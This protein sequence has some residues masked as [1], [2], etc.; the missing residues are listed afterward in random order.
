MQID[1]YYRFEKNNDRKSK[2]RYELTFNQGYYEPLHQ[3]N[4][5][6]ECWIYFGYNPRIKT[7]NDRKSDVA[8]STRVSKHITSVFI[9]E[10]EQPNLAYG[11]YGNDAFLI[12]VNGIIGTIEIMIF[13]GQKHIQT[14]LNNLFLDGEF[15]E[16]LQELRTLSTASEK[17]ELK[18]VQNVV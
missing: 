3:T 4:K 2:T 5:K 13:K 8:I 6:G 17:T 10:P 14:T 15:D 18:L 12:V 11:D 16:D 1:A 9:P 7:R